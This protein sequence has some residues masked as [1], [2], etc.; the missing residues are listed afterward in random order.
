ML[1][2]SRAR[3][4]NSGECG[5]AAAQWIAFNRETR[6]AAP[7]QPQLDT[8]SV[9]AA[10]PDDNADQA[11]APSLPPPDVLDWNSEA[12]DDAAEESSEATSSSESDA[13]QGPLL[14]TGLDGYWDDA[15]DLDSATLDEASLLASFGGNQPTLRRAAHTPDPLQ[16]AALSLAGSATPSVLLELFEKYHCPQAMRADFL[17]FLKSPNLSIE[18][19]PSTPSAFERFAQAVIPRSAEYEIIISGKAVIFHDLLEVLQEALTAEPDLTTA[20]SDPGSGCLIHLWQTGRWKELD[21]FFA[22]LVSEGHL[23]VPV[24]VFLDGYEVF[25]TSQKSLEGVYFRLAGSKTPSR[26]YLLCNAPPGINKLELLYHVVVAPLLRLEKGLCIGSRRLCGGLYFLSADHIGACANSGCLGPA[27]NFPSRYSLAPS[28]KLSDVSG[29]E[30]DLRDP[31][32]AAA[33]FVQTTEM[34]KSKGNIGR[35]QELLRKIGLR[36]DQSPLWLLASFR[37]S[38]FQNFVI[39]FL[40]ANLLGVLRRHLMALMEEWPASKC[41]EFD[42]HCVELSKG[43]PFPG[44]ARLWAVLNTKTKFGEVTVKAITGAEMLS[45]LSV[46]MVALHG[47]VSSAALE[48]WRLHLEC[49]AY[50][51]GDLTLADIDLVPSK[52]LA[53]QRAA[54]AALASDRAASPRRSELTTDWFNVPNFEAQRHWARMI[55]WL[56]PV[57]LQSTAGWEAFH[58]AMKKAAR[59][60]NKQAPERDIIRQ[61]NRTSHLGGMVRFREP[62]MEMPINKPRRLEPTYCLAGRRSADTAW[63]SPIERTAV[64]QA[65]QL[66]KVELKAGLPNRVWKRTALRWPCESKMYLHAGDWVELRMRVGPAAVRGRTEYAKLLGFFEFKR[67]T[68]N[69]KDMFARVELFLPIV[70]TEGSLAAADTSF[71]QLKS[72]GETVM[73]ISVPNYEFKGLVRVLPSGREFVVASRGCPMISP[74]SSML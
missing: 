70:A 39:C 15:I 6:A 8:E 69:I 71:V 34:L 12:T 58:Q 5:A 32:E 60:T 24:C 46:S 19:I 65:F 63:R 53:W 48:G 55:R 9:V 42:N 20:Y 25:A 27:A 57:R 29:R 41:E 21:S 64:T 2:G 45:F 66:A 28:D 56:G 14:D 30:F 18:S 10:H 68:T 74:T 54:V 3:H 62:G 72:V 59:H 47:R 51:L 52:I 67:P 17:K 40:H 37:K 7:T 22:P 33:A 4:L 44:L 38:Y 26:K 16:M 36:P 43:C 1:A 49:T 11:Y 31:A 61:V 50:L 35:V 13:E 73:P 23:L